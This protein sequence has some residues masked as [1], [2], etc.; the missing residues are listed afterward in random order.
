MKSLT[1]GLS[2]VGNISLAGWGPRGPP[3][4]WLEK[5]SDVASS[6][7]QWHFCTFS[8][9]LLLEDTLTVFFTTELPRAD[10]GS[11]MR[12][13]LRCCW[14]GYSNNRFHTWFMVVN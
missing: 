5:L 13:K 2:R 8:L 7:S 11:N 10:V 3:H 4:L 6:R 12:Y 14:D 9:P 1:E